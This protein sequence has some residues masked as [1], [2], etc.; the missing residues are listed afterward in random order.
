MQDEVLI[1]V[2]TPRANEPTSLP[3]MPFE[4]KAG[5]SVNV[6]C[7]F[8]AYGQLSGSPMTVSIPVN[9]MKCTLCDLRC[10][11]SAA[12]EIPASRFKE[13]T[14]SSGSSKLG[15]FKGVVP[16][17]ELRTLASAGVCAN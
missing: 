16:A 4:K 9:L 8:S 6:T 15:V 3:P 2:L 5:S 7:I 10:F 14:W 17:S 11:A 12:L 13:I 1:G